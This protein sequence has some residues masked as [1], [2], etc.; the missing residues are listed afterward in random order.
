LLEGLGFETRWGGGNFAHFSTPAQRPNHPPVESVLELFPGGKAA[1]VW[2]SKPTP[3][4]A[5]VK[6][7][8]E[9]DLQTSPA[10]LHG[11]L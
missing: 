8:L 7:K 1:G 6:E 4:S 9:L 5:E 2:P 11:I 10:C 3:S